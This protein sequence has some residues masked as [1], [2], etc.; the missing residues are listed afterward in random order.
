LGI[1]AD[2][3]VFAA[4]AFRVFDLVVICSSSYAACIL[5]RH[6]LR[7]KRPRQGVK[8]LLA[9]DQAIERDSRTFGR[10]GKN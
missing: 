10:A 5:E 3:V 8:S 9:V 6:V 7:T 1:G 4:G 2:A